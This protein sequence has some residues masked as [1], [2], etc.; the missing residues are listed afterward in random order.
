[1]FYVFHGNDTFSCAEELAAL[2]AKMGDPAMAGL[3]TTHLDG[4]STTL[5]ELLHHCDTIPFLSD[6]RLVIVGGLLARLAPRG[7]QASAE[8]KFLEEL[9][10]YLPHVPPTTRLVFVE[11]K[12]LSLRHP[13]LALAQSSGAG[14][15]KAFVAPT[16][17]GLVRWVRNRVR[18]AGAQI[19]AHA[20]EMLCTFVG[21]DLYLLYNE[22]EKLAAYTDGQRPITEE[23]LQLLTPQLRQAS[24][25]GMVDALG[26]RDGKTASSIYHDLLD[27]GDHPLAL[28]GM[29]TR[30][31]RL[32]IQVKE[33]AS[34]L[35]TPEDI[36]RELH[37]NPYPITK[38][39]SQSKN[40][41]MAQLHLVYRKLLDTDVEIK[42]GKIEPTLALD[43]LIAGLGRAV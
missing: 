34:E 27:A 3:N 28:L 31:F 2:T 32:M 12:R 14:Y 9:V 20:A 10:A 25:F 1:M 26:R 36:A 42:T 5:D 29:I 11:S 6:R 19:E 4:H 39:L 23:D 15:V 35:I 8:A 38:I 16:G 41:S 22:I 7:A 30:Q 37:Q 24:I 17:S 13:V 21:D 18:Q 33:L 43:T 40:F